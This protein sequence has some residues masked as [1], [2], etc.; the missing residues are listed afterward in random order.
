MDKKYRI[1]IYCDV[2]IPGSFCSGA[3]ATVIYDFQD[4]LDK[5]SRFSYDIIIMQIHKELSNMCEVTACI[6]TMT[7][8]PVLFLIRKSEKLKKD[9]IQVGADAVLDIES[10]T[11][12]IELEI[13]ALVR[14]Y[15]YWNSSKL[16]KDRNDEPQAISG[17]F[18]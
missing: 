6:R 14:R 16:E 18:M 2:K 4:C 5:L 15:L 9:L 11:E 8:I 17:I 7:L 1:L 12:E 10:S 3:E 13:F